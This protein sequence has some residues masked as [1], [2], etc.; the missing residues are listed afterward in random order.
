MPVELG[1][2]GNSGV[3]VSEQLLGRSDREG[4]Y[5]ISGKAQSVW[6]NMWRIL[7]KRRRKGKIKPY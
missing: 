5:R 3:G 4:L 1:S 7:F 2:K 6:K